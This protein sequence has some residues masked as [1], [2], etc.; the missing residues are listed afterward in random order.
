[1]TVLQEDYYCAGEVALPIRWCAPETLH[2]TDT[3]IETKEVCVIILPL[4]IIVFMNVLLK[5]TNF[6]TL[7]PSNARSQVKLQLK[8]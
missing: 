4:F 5:R 3:T 6:L 8:Y 2:C 7:L 1:M